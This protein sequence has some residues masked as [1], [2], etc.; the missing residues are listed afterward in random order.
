[1]RWRTLWAICSA[2]TFCILLTPLLVHIQ[3]QCDQYDC[4]AYVT[5]SLWDYGDQEHDNPEGVVVGDKVIVMA[6]LESD[7]T[8][9]VAEELPECAAS[10][11]F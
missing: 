11:I 1:M 5:S 9:W 8:S 2:V 3:D 4:P 7:H 10:S 6:A